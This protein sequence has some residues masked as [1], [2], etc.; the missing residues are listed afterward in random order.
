[1]K[2]A[3]IVNF[4]TDLANPDFAALARS[5]GLYGVRAE[6]PDELDAAVRDAFD[7]PGPAVIDIATS[8]EELSLPPKITTEQIKGFTLFA[9]RTVLS[10]RG[11]EIVELAK[12][13]L[14]QLSVE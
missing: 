13:N 7:H 3:G 12:T 4:G 1:M 14:R 9:V 10:G 2:A 6:K 8:R 5:I 11:D